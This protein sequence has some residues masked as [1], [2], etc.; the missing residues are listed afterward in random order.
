[1]LTILASGTLVADPVSRTASNGKTFATGLLRV[2]VEDGEPVL[3]SVIA[4]NAEAVKAI[5]ALAKGDACSIAGRAKL[6]NWT[7]QDGTENR[8]LNV[9]C[10]KVLTPYLIDKKRRASQEAVVDEVEA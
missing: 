5:L 1:M 8:G 3:F 6:T 7:G 4:F 10:E 9:V 2:P